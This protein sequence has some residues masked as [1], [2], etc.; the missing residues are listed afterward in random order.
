LSKAIEE[1]RKF[2]FVTSELD[3]K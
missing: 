3:Y 2:F 1:L